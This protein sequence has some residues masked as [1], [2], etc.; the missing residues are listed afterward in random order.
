MNDCSS[1]QHEAIVKVTFVQARFILVT[2]VP[3]I[4]ARAVGVPVGRHLG[5]RLATAFVAAIN[6]IIFFSLSFKVVVRPSY[7]AF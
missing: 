5:S 6:V 7:A 3:V 4:M 2:F 1:I